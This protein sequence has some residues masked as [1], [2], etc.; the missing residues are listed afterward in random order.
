MKVRIVQTPRE[1]ELDGIRLD[2]FSRGEVRE[3]SSI[4]GSWLIAQQYAEFEMRQ[5]SREEDQAFAGVKR[6]RDVAHD[7]RHRSSDD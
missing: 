2:N 3:V 5:T 4:I 7:R 6:P 1:H